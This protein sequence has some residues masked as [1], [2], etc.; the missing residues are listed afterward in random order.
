MSPFRLRHKSNKSE[1]LLKNS[2]FKK[3]GFMKG[4]KRKILILICVNII[5][6]MALFFELTHVYAATNEYT[7]IHSQTLLEANT[8]DKLVLNYTSLPSVTISGSETYTIKDGVTGDSTP[9]REVEFVN[10]TK[11]KTLNSVITVKFSN[12][13]K[14]N[15]KAIDMKLVYSDI[16]TKANNPLFYWTAY[17]KSMTSSNEWWYGNI[18]H[19]TLKIYF[20][21]LNSNT[22]ITL[23]TAYLSLFSEDPNEGASS[24]RASEQYLYAKTN[25]KYGA[26]ISSRYTSRTYKNV[27]YG[28]GST[29]G[30]TEAG[31]LECV[32]F[33]Y[34][35]TNNIEVELYALSENASEKLH[36]RL[37]SAIRFTYCQHSS[38]SQKNSR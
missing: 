29:L 31:T 23:D 4:K 24:K 6:F 12:C 30:S 13:G 11:G 14:L 35:N 3:E 19:A 1:C 18:E 27:F 32:S 36:V 28:V 22:P 10:T 8:L 5:F 15:G 7:V 34:K 26:S 38:S 33:Q 25:M 17:G 9:K 2:I 37:S 16:V 20:Y 21:N